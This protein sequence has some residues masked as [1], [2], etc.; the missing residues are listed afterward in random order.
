MPRQKN[1]PGQS[2]IVDGDPGSDRLS[3]GTENYLLCLYKLW[4]DSE[5]PTI[6]QLTDTLKQLPTTE[7]LGTSVPSVAGMIRRMQRQTLVEIGGDK[8]IRLTR[9]GLEGAEDIARRHRLAEWLVV[10]LLGMELYQAHNEAHR[11]EH[12]M[13]REFEQKLVERLGNPKRSPYGRPIPGSGEPRM[14][15]NAVTLDQA[16]P[17]M[18]HM[19]DRVPEED[20]QLLR[21]LSDSMIVPECQVTVVEA[22]PYLGVLE[23]AT[24][25]GNV[26]I[27]YNVAQ[28]ILV[29]TIDQN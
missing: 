5:I 1:D 15:A 19:V 27:G 29:R 23:L 17:G 8:R 9:R 22:T 2:V 18:A 10:R 12:G 7:G 28:Q 20:S 26:S 11:L 25:L 24:Q 6:T 14:P 3:S 4:E 16:T 21:F 13:S